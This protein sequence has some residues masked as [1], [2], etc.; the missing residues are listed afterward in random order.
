MNSI[1]FYF[2]LLYISWHSINAVVFWIAGKFAFFGYLLYI[3]IY[4]ACLLVVQ[5]C[6]RDHL[7]KPKVLGRWEALW[8][9]FQS[10]ESAG[11]TV[12][13]ITPPQ[14][15]FVSGGHFAEEPSAKDCFGKFQGFAEEHLPVGDTKGKRSRRNSSL[16]KR[17]RATA[18]QQM[19]R[20]WCN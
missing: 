7:G 12:E 10:T 5:V 14:D 8:P 4:M 17:Y 2:I 11:K 16:L 18:E 1:P 15:F 20:S 6:G 3:Y 19:K 9:D 13:G